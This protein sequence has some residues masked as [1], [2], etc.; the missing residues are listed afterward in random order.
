VSTAIAVRQAT[1]DDLPSI[2]ELRLA[3]LRE[4]GD[5]PIYGRLRSDVT[6][7]AFELYRTQVTS[8]MELLLLAE[9]S[10]RIV[11]IMRCVD[12]ATSPLLLPERYCYVSSVY[13]RPAER[14]RGVLRALMRAAEEWCVD[15]GLAEMR[16]HNSTSNPTARGAW[17]ALGFEVVEEVRR[18]VLP[19]RPTTP[20]ST[21]AHAG[22]R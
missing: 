2:V 5:H 3:L 14:K 12:A 16:L 13:V 1:V 7:R 10:H 17:Q 20:R 11:G 15:R 6:E 9:R 21:R 8:P 22:V 4:Y 18:R 19:T